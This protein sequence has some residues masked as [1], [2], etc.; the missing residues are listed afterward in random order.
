MRYQSSTRGLMFQKA[1]GDA[2]IAPQLVRTRPS[3]SMG[4]MGCFVAVINPNR[5]LLRTVRRLLR[6]TFGIQWRHMDIVWQGGIVWYICRENVVIGFLLEFRDDVRQ[7]HLAPV[8]RGARGSDA[9]HSAGD[10]DRTR[11]V[12]AGNIAAKI[13]SLKAPPSAGGTEEE[14]HHCQI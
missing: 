4:F 5:R 6:Y 2:V 7:R 13:Y 8:V 11:D 12:R 3:M 9:E 14:L 1:S 10:R